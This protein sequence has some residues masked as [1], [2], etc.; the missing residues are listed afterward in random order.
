MGVYSMLTDTGLSQIN[1]AQPDV[2][3]LIE[4]SHWV[5][6]FD[7]K[8]ANDFAAGDTATYSN[9]ANYTAPSETYPNQYRPGITG[10]IVYW[11]DVRDQLSNPGKG[12]V[13]TNVTYQP[14]VN[15]N[16]TDYVGVWVVGTSYPS[17][18]TK[19]EYWLCSGSGVMSDGIFYSDNGTPGEP[20]ADILVYN[21]T[22]FANATN[23]PDNN[24]RANFKVT[25]TA[26][27]E[28]PLVDMTINKVSIYGSRRSVDGVIQDD[29]FLLGQIIIPDAQS[30][31]PQV[32]GSS[33][34]FSLA[35]LVID[36]QIDTAAVLVDFD[37]IIYASP[38][39]Y[40]VHAVNNDGQYGLLY[41]GQV[42]ITNRL[43]MEDQNGVFPS[44]DDAG[45]SKLLVATSE[46]V[47][48]PIPNEEALMP[49][50]ILQYNKSENY[51][52]G[53][54]YTQ[55]IRTSFW[56]SPDGDCEVNMYGSCSNGF[57]YYSFIPAEDRLFGLGNNT[58][59][60]KQLKTSERIEL[61]LGAEYDGPYNH[62]GRW[63]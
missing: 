33:D 60:W 2:G 47:N 51:E 35:S 42:Y 12:D 20:G 56:T 3:I 28:K 46:T 40:W 31:S 61:Y 36:F 19:G 54:S 25:V 27:K 16:A 49:Q 34:N 32:D 5:A 7:Q 52:S 9:I 10:D 39:D 62:D 37:N 50:L 17:S 21:G 24:Y 4:V 55:R 6:S 8:L 43:G 45:V 23:D 15:T 1:N 63:D 30:V 29:V 58:N 59:R 57:G 13:Y 44:T 38:D 53:N 14:V 26:D 18:P 22:V 48:K 41:D 11:K